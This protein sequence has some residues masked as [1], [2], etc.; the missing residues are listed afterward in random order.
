MS[1]LE[2]LVKKHRKQFPYP[3]RIVR[4]EDRVVMVF[5]DARVVKKGKK[6][7]C[8]CGEKECK[9]ITGTLYA[10]LMERWK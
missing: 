9:H 4:K 2:A 7:K 6:I 8:S 5:E 10:L 3:A 1:R